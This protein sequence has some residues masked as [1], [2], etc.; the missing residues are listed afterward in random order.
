[1]KRILAMWAWCELSLE[2]CQIPYLPL[3]RYYSP[4]LTRNWKASTCM[5]DPI[6]RNFEVFHLRRNYLGNHL[7]TNQ[8]NSRKTLVISLD[9]CNSCQYLDQVPWILEVCCVQSTYKYLQQLPEC[10]QPQ[11]LW[12]QDQH[13]WDHEGTLL[14]FKSLVWHLRSGDNLAC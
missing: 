3:R 12:I 8:A 5:S 11:P 14:A 4:S 2:V 9:T 1:M 7:N 10:N 13:F 6:L